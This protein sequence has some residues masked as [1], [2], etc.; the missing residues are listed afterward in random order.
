MFSDSVYFPRKGGSLKE[1][2]IKRKSFIKTGSG[3]VILKG[4]HCSFSLWSGS[5][6]ESLC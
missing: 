6:G 1:M 4:R 2:K 5:S 3:H